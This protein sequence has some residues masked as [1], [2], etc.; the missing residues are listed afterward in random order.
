MKLGCIDNDMMGLD[1][2]YC[3][4]EENMLYFRYAMIG[5]HGN[6]PFEKLT[7]LYRTFA[8]MFVFGHRNNL[9]RGIPDHLFQMCSN[10]T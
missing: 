2:R 1:L 4:V 5:Y 6:I 10:I 8:L 9:G 3:N 7:L